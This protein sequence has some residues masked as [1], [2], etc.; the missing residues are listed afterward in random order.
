[1][2]PIPFLNEIGGRFKDRVKAT[3]NV[4][5]QVQKFFKG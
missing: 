2:V 5:R 3:L 4:D 1:M